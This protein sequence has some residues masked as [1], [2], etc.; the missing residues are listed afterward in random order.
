MSLAVT[1]VWWWPEWLPI[2]HADRQT[3]LAVIDKRI[4][5][6]QQE[7]LF[8]SEWEAEDSTAGWR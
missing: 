7:L 6:L 3:D 2:Q 8:L 5:E 1:D 4:R